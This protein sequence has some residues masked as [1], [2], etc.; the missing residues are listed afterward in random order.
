[1]QPRLSVQAALLKHRHAGTVTGEVSRKGGVKIACTCLILINLPQPM[2]LHFW[3]T[4]PNK[5]R[6]IRKQLN[7][8]VAT[9]D[10]CTFLDT[11]SNSRAFVEFDDDND[12]DD[13]PTRSAL[14]RSESFHSQSWFNYPI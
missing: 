8:K 12:D 3:G 13:Y 4:R 11:L 6:K 7:V 10:I 9:R 1:M 2:G 14:D 5:N